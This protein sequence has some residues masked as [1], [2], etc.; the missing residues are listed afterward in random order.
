MK[1]LGYVLVVIGFITAALTSVVDTEQ[2]P[3]LLYGPALGLGFLGVV[4]LRLV[5]QRAWSATDQQSNTIQTLAACLQ[6]IVDNLAHLKT[7][8]ASDPREVHSDIDRTFAT[9]L[10]TFVNGRESIARL[11]GLQA[12][13][14]IMSSF[15]AAERYLNRVWSA[16]VDGYIDEVR[17]YINHAHE[18]FT[19]SLARI[20]QLPDSIRT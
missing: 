12:Y 14:D 2:T 17:T 15:A 18:Q 9:D 20:E 10:A 8:I 4:A 3:W 19:D 6:R 11:H 16:S 7:S 5:R 1:I 13:A